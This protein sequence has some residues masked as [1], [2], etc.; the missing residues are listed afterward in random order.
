M[1]QPKPMHRLLRFVAWSIVLIF[2][3]PSS[4]AA[5]FGEPTLV[6]H[7]G[8]LHQQGPGAAKGALIWSPGARTDI[9]GDQGHPQVK[10][11]WVPH[12][13]EYLYAQGWDVFYM[14]REGSRR[15]DARPQHTAA[16]TAAVDGLQNAGYQK[17]VLAGQSSGGTYSLLATIDRPS[18]HALLLFASGPGQRQPDP[19]FYDLLTQTHPAKIAA[20]HFTEDQTIGR[21]SESKLLSILEA[22]ESAYLNIFEP[23]GH[24]GHGAGFKAKFSKQYG[25]CFLAFLEAEFAPGPFFCSAH[26]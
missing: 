8:F 2:A 23:Q 22:K 16:L 4:S 1:T 9:E 7:D 6:I 25:D 18:I 13:I 21:R 14:Q 10:G 3:L 12:I 24:S 17:V 5:E 19:S 20:L 11:A 26:K 15:I